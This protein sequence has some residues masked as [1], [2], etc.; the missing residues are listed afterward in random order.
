[1]GSRKG[2]C[3]KRT[4]NKS[5]YANKVQDTDEPS[6]LGGSEEGRGRVKRGALRAGLEDTALT[7]VRNARVLT[8]AETA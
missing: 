3:Q 7:H 6:L 5:H 8:K 1:M 4:L 2:Q